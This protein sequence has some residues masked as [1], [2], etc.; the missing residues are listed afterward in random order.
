MAKAPSNDTLAAITA[1]DALF[2]EWT[3][4]QRAHA[5]YATRVASARNRVRAIPAEIVA[6]ATDPKQV[7]TLRQERTEA[8]LLLR[9]ADDILQGLAAAAAAASARWSAQ[10]H[11]ARQAV[12][13][14]MLGG[15]EEKRAAL[16]A[17]EAAARAAC[18]ER[19]AAMRS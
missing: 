4:A 11:V 9:D 1:A 19:I 7:A 16:D 8:E 10:W 3:D 12:E 13:G 18:A 5:A 14:E 17:A 2:A 15:L 6:G